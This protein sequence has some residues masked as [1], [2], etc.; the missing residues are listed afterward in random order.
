MQ[1]TLALAQGTKPEADRSEALTQAVSEAANAGLQRN[2]EHDTARAEDQAVLQYTRQRCGE[3]LL[4]LELAEIAA[5]LMAAAK[6][7]PTTSESHDER[8]EEGPPL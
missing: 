4:R 5:C 2:R 7:S 1:A 8:L 6:D 3:A